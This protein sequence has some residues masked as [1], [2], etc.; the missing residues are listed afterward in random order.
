MKFP[1]KAAPCESI[2]SSTEKSERQPKYY[3]P[4]TAKVRDGP[5]VI[6]WPL[7]ITVTPRN[8]PLR[9]NCFLFES[10]LV[11][12]NLVAL[13]S[14]WVVGSNLESASC[15]EAEQK[16]LNIACNSV[17][18]SL[19]KERVEWVSSGLY[20]AE[21]AATQIFVKRG[22][23]SEAEREWEFSECSGLHSNTWKALCVEYD[24][25]T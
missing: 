10:C 7:T 19:M 9:N 11:W 21:G 20:G 14:G 22:A 17:Y 23:T 2:C 12:I 18:K 8:A 25:L 15:C 4:L 3:T 5:Y 16:H 13:R 24:H 6:A 1:L